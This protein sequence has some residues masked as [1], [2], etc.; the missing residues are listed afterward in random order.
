MKTANINF[1]LNGTT[2]LIKAEY[3]NTNVTKSVWVWVNGKYEPVLNKIFIKDLLLGRN[4]Y[5]S[6]PALDIE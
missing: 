5:L 2:Y 1:K 4:K 6:I 3:I